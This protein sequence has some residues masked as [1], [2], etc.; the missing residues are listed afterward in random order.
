MYFKL[1]VRHTFLAVTPH[2]D[3]SKTQCKK[4]IVTD[5]FSTYLS[6]QM[7]LITKFVWLGN[8]II[9]ITRR[10]IRLFALKRSIWIIL[11]NRAVTTAHGALAFSSI[12]KKKSFYNEKLNNQN[13]SKIVIILRSEKWFRIH[14][15]HTGN[16]RT[17]IGAGQK[18][19][20]SPILAGSGSRNPVRTTVKY[21]EIKN[22]YHCC[23]LGE[24]LF[25]FFTYDIATL[26]QVFAT[27]VAYTWRIN[28]QNLLL[29][30]LFFYRQLV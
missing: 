23:F 29:F 13:E 2:F 21:K 6:P 8:K 26:R 19:T 22:S 15:K 24:N 30:L 18:Q 9:C 12:K 28:A 27:S 20:K 14:L 7:Q 25:S 10:V 3:Y 11:M 16:H 5:I 17:I 4:N 1:E